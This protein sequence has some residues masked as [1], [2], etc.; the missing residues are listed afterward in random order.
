MSSMWLT[1]GEKDSAHRI[2]TTEGSVFVWETRRQHVFLEKY[3][4]HQHM[5]PTSSPLKLSDFY[6]QVWGPWS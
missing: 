4:F 2:E 3:G 6:N 5:A 1:W